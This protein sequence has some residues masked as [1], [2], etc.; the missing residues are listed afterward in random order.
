MSSAPPVTPIDLSGFAEI[1]DNARTDNSSGVVATIGRDGPD[2]GFKGSLFV[3]D[4]DHVAWWERTLRET[5]AAIQNDSR[6]CVLV[7]NTTRDR[8][9]IRLYGTATIVDD[10][11]LRE[12]IWGRVVQSEKDMDKETKGA[13]ILVRVDRVRAGLDTIQQRV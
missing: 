13:A 10:P 3:W 12:R 6:V 11:E 5:Y 9:T 1:I 7:R 4:K 2:V 8:R